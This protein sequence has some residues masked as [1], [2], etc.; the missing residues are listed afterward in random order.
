LVYVCYTG[1]GFILVYTF[2]HTITL[3]T[4][5]PTHSSLRCWLRLHTH[6]PV[7]LPFVTQLRSPHTHTGSALVCAYTT[8]HGSLCAPLFGYGYRFNTVTH[9][10][11]GYGLVWLVLVPTTGRYHTV[12]FY[13]CGS[14]P[15]SLRG[16]LPFILL[17]T[18]LRS[19]AATTVVTHVY[20]PTRFR[21]HTRC[22]T[23]THTVRCGC[24]HTH[25]RLQVT[26]AHALWTPRLRFPHPTHAH[27]HT[28][29]HLRVYSVVATFVTFT[30]RLFV[31]YMPLPTPCRSVVHTVCSLLTFTVTFVTL[32]FHYVY[33]ALICSLHL[34]FHS[35]R[36]SAYYNVKLW[37]LAL[38]YWQP[39]LRASSL[40]AASPSSYF[41]LL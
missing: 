12:G 41:A 33:V 18:L 29:T 1:F 22:V 36:R 6:T 32:L 26:H 38:P 21:T 5:L 8:L 37:P 16:L 13:T 7:W 27:C 25:T 34:V 35:N 15:Y 17:P 40:V 28:R 23:H 14:L 2:T 31:C 9:H 39:L 20:T 10:T 24:T 11:F 4:R 19:A 3:H 30:L